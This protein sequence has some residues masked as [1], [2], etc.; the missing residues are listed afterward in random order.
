MKAAG[1]GIRRSARRR[2]PRASPQQRS[3]KSRQTTR[4]APTAGHVT[5]SL[6]DRVNFA[7]SSTL[8]NVVQLMIMMSNDVPLLW[9]YKF[10]QA[11]IKVLPNA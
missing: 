4:K 1:R 9:S 5:L 11:Y 3:R 10:A 6:N 7:K 2:P 8:C